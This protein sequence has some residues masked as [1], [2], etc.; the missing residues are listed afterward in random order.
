MSTSR[1]IVGHRAGET[2]RCGGVAGTDP[3]DPRGL[4]GD[5][6]LPPQPVRVYRHGQQPGVTGMAAAQD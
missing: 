3:R 5:A 4:R 6:P 2:S 1:A